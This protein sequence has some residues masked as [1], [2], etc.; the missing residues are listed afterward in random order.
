[1]PAATPAERSGQLR[2]KLEKA[3]YAVPVEDLLTP[4]GTSWVEE[5][6]RS[7][8]ERPAVTPRSATKAGPD[9]LRC[10]HAVT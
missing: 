2:G 7:S 6:R 8:K 4:P 9:A 10:A 1:M 3:H 5:Y